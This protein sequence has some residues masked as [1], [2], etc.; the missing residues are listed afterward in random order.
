MPPRLT[1]QKVKKAQQELD[2]LYEQR[3]LKA[4]DVH[5]D[6][7]PELVPRVLSLFALGAQCV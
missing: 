6:K 7:N 5:L 3:C 4:I 2:A 1:D